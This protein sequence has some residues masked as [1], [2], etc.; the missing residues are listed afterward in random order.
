MNARWLLPLLLL[1]LLAQPV[2]SAAANRTAGRAALLDPSFGESGRVMLPPLDS[3]REVRVALMG[4]DG[5]VISTGHT[6]RRLGPDGRLDGSFG[7]GGSVTPP[8]RPGSEFEI[9]GVAVD[10]AGHLIVA[11]TA[12]MPEDPATRTEFGRGFGERPQAARVLR[13]LPNGVLD[14][15][16]GAGGVVETDFGLPPTYD[17]DG[18]RIL[19][20]PW[21]E[22][23]GVAVDSQG[24]VLLTGG[25]SAGLEF[26]CMHD[27]FW[28][29]VTY[30][31]YVARLTPAG[32]L[33]PSFGSGGVFGGR[34]AGENRLRAE[35]SD[36]P[37]I[38]P[39]D[40]VTYGSG[41]GHCPY[42]EGAS[43]LGRLS[44]SGAPDPGFGTQG[45]VRGAPSEPLVLP[46]GRIAG[47][48]LARTWYYPKESA[49]I[50]VERLNS[51][52]RPDRSFGTRG[53]TVLRTPGG[54][55]SELVAVAA[56]GRGRLLLGG[57]MYTRRPGKS[58][59]P[60]HS[61]LILARLT[62]YGRLERSFAPR[63]RVAARFGSR[64]LSAS[65]LLVDSQGRAVLVGTYGPWDHEGVAIARYTISR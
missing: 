31:A 52:G 32:A 56:G 36:S 25:A 42:G 10:P 26:G 16:F 23:T 49:P 22:V 9:E 37:S 59:K 6:L 51:N 28:D 45:T 2:S 11:G 40:E 29:T 63:G 27:W 12:V 7:L 65:R 34:K 46:D 18:K 62:A 47:I 24:R 39:E 3:E 35:V 43:G 55:L 41:R 15:E 60:R 44:S 5:F 61:S 19:A 48:G 17:E 38:G 30:A 58:K 8:A 14:P 13:Y 53:T 64:T 20:E 54:P 4:D 33:D 57:T 50:E 21:V 1:T